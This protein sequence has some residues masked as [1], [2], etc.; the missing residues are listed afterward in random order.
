[1]VRFLFLLI[2]SLITFDVC[3]GS[4]LHIEINESIPISL[5][6]CLKFFA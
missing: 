4:L 5:A 6:D 3:F 2:Q 1:M